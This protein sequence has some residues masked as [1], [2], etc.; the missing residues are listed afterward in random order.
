MKKDYINELKR[1]RQLISIRESKEPRSNAK[2]SGVLE[3]HAQGA[4]G[5]N[6][7]IIREG[8]KFYIKVAPKKHTQLVSEDFDYIGG[9]MNKKQHEYKSY[10]QASKS[11][12][13]KMMAINESC[14]KKQPVKR[15]KEAETTDWQ[16][17]ETKEMRNEINR[18]TN[19]LSYMENL[20]EGKEGC[21]NSPFCD[22]P[23]FGEPKKQTDF[24][25]SG[26]PFSQGG[27]LSNKDVYSDKVSEKDGGIASKKVKAKKG[28]VKKYNGKQFKVN[29]SQY[30]RY[31]NDKPETI[32]EITLNEDTLNVFGQHPGYRK[33]PM[34][35]PPNVEIN[36]YGRDWDHSSVKGDSPFGQKIGDTAPYTEEAIIELLTDTIT[37][38]ILKKKA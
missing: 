35:L 30:N 15:F 11:F 6:Y 7:G 12:D 4:D 38:R 31:F 8:T 14:N 32:F 16:I 22:K 36:T 1:M 9:L 24:K 25:K 5:K 27:T 23:T 19:I 37:D 21:K 33:S 17:R 18:F 26:S 3:Y 29:E 13:L 2:D 34:T 20:S 28:D 10:N